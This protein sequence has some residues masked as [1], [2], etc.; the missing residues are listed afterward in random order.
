MKLKK[1]KDL[2]LFKEEATEIFENVKLA[3]DG[4]SFEF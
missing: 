2:N 1:I 4:K 3:R